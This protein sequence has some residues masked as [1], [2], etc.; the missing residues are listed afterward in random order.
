MT[1]DSEEACLVRA[2]SPT[3]AHPFGNM[4]YTNGPTGQVNASNH[5]T[6]ISM[7]QTQ[8]HHNQPQHH[9]SQ[10]SSTQRGSQSHESESGDLIDYNDEYVLSQFHA[11][12]IK[13]AGCG[14]FQIIASIVAGLGLAGH[15]IQVYAVFYIVPSAEVEY[16]ILDNEKNWLGECCA[17]CLG[18][19][20]MD[21]Q[22]RFLQ[23]Q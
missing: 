23:G 6:P 19:Q 4:L 7:Q 12:A 13:Q 9:A 22:R 14:K 21:N 3:I 8:H 18:D 16:C 11:D 10:N 1:E 17:Q 5:Q 2:Q 20:Q 15:A